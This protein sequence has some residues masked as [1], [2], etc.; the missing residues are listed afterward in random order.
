M[1]GVIVMN[2]KVRID[3][4]DLLKAI[5]ILMVIS[6]HVPLWHIDF[7]DKNSQ[8][9]LLQ[10]GFRLL[11]EGVPIFVTVNGFLLLGKKTLDPE[12][13]YKKSLKLFGLLC[14]WIVVYILVGMAVRGIRF[15]S[16]TLS[17]FLVY[18]FET[19]SDSGSTYSGGLWFLQYLLSVYLIYPVLWKSYHDD[20]SVFKV[21]FF[22]MFILLVGRRSIVMV[23]N[24][25]ALSA[26]TPVLNEVLGFLKRLTVWG[27]GWYVLFFC[28]G[29][30][31]RHYFER[32]KSKKKAFIGLGIISWVCAVIYGYYISVKSGKVFDQSFNYCSP[33]IFLTILGLFAAV[34]DYEVTNQIDRLLAGIGKNTFQIYIVH[35]LILNIVKVLR[36]DVLQSQRLISFIVVTCISYILALAINKVPPI[37]RFFTI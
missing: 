6:L 11:S 8:I 9:R 20:F 15:S 4:L 13:H 29:G 18:F 10:Y 23:K 31:I 17:D 22:I 5:A 21:F 14:F 24:I 37:K 30:M 26:D 32:I 7:I 12:K 36:P 2:E 1:K 34:S 27:D 35:K 19:G 33:F 16:I 28:F 25:V 3:G